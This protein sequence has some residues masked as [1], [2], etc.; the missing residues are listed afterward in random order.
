MKPL[1][2]VAEW[3]FVAVAESLGPSRAAT[4]RFLRHCRWPGRHLDVLIAVGEVVQNIIRH[5]FDAPDYPAAFSISIVATEDELVVTIRD[6]APPSN[7]QNWERDN[8]P[9]VEG[10]HGLL[11]IHGLASAVTFSSHDQGNRVILRFLSDHPVQEF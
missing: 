7:P 10:G 1:S 8:R 9:A 2:I 11:L 4:R 6:S 5:A 3:K